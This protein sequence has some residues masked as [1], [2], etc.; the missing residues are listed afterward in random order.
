MKDINATVLINVKDKGEDELFKNIDYSRRKNINKAKRSGLYS[1]EVNSEKDYEECYKMYANVISEGGSTPFSYKVWRNWAMEEHWKLFAIKKEK[2]TIGYFSVIE[3][4]KRYYGLAED[5]SKGIRPRVFASDK[6]FHEFRT[7][8]FIYWNTI[9]YGLNKGF[10]F[11]DLGG[12]QIKPRGHLIGV[13]RFKEQWGGEIFYFHLDYGIVSAIARKL[14]RNFNL[15]WW[16]NEKIKRHR[17]KIP[18]SF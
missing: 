14:V 1:E 6:R 11:V 3:I 15:F 12:Y 17:P 8:D 18:E 7:N 13:N 10:D 4:A 5:G 9:L 16:I 2:L